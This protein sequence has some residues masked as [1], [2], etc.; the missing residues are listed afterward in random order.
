[1]PKVKITMTE[2]VTYSREVVM[3]DAE[4]HEWDRKTDQ[5]GRPGDDAVEE[6][7]AKFIRPAHDWQ[8]ADRLELQD[9]SLVLED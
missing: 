6:L 8:D 3:T 2:R 7:R 1:M 4:W 5:R 9:L